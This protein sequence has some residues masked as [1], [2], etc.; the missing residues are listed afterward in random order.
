MSKE[1][2]HGRRLGGPSLRVLQGWG[3]VKCAAS[4]FELLGPSAAGSWFAV[5][6]MGETSCVGASSGSTEIPSAS[7]RAGSSL[8]LV[9]ALGAQRPILV[10]DDKTR[11][12]RCGPILLGRWRTGASAPHALLCRCSANGKSRFLP[13]VGM[14]RFCLV[15][16]TRLVGGPSFTRADPFHGLILSRACLKM[17]QIERG[18]LALEGS[19]TACC[20]YFGSPQV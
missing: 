12:R 5:K 7:L 17:M 3:E 20:R 16:M 14:T 15:G 9:F 10:Q 1:V 4:A 8:R 13:L 18:F 11:K 19:D 2:R 6:R